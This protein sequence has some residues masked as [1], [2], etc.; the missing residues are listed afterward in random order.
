LHAGRWGAE[1]FLRNGFWEETTERIVV[2]T[3]YLTSGIDRYW[4]QEP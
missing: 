4:R 3:A 2:L 1:K